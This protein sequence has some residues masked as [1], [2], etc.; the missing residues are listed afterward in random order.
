MAN[1]NTNPLK[2]ISPPKRISA[3]YPIKNFLA[4]ALTFNLKINLLRSLAYA[5]GS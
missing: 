2:R 4:F 1:L 3:I 5:E